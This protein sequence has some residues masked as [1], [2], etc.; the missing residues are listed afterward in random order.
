MTVDASI[1]VLGVEMKTDGIVMFLQK[2]LY[3]ELGVVVCRMK[4]SCGFQ[5]DTFVCVSLLFFWGGGLG[6]LEWC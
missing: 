1:G 3:I 2:D 5:K 6:W 4:N